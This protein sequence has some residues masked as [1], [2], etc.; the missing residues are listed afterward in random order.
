MIRPEIIVALGAHAARTLLHTNDSIGHLRGRFHTYSISS[1]DPPIK[2]MATYH[3][4]YLL[5]YY[6]QDNRARV[7]EDMKKVMSELNIP[8]P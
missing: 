8:V 5:R 1:D 6:T 7:W 2:L 4:A 3:P